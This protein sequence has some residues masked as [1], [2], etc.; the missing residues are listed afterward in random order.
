[1]TVASSSWSPSAAPTSRSASRASS[2]ASKTECFLEVK[3]QPGRDRIIIAPTA[4]HDLSL[5][6]PG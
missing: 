3:D 6:D 5:A 4:V 1:M 2:S